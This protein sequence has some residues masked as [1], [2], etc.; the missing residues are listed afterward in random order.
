M[1]R[2][3]LMLRGCEGVRLMNGPD[4][5]KGLIDE[6]A[7]AGVGDDSTVPTA[8]G[9]SLCEFSPCGTLLARASAVGV[10]IVHTENSGAAPL[11]ISELAGGRVQKIGACTLRELPG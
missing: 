7:I 3:K 11:L 2:T 10:E 1:L 4:G 6:A 5:G 8:P 9:C